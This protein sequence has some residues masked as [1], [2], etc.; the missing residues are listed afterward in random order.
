MEEA[1]AELVKNLGLLHRVCAWE[2]LLLKDIVQ[3]KGYQIVQP[4]TGPTPSSEPFLPVASLIANGEL[5]TAGI[6]SDTPESI[7]PTDGEKRKRDHR[8]RNAQAL[9]HLLHGLAGAV[10]PFFQG[11][12]A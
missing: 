6:S 8:D 2:S 10:A 5:S 12:S 4:Y 3:E 11:A 9:R 1:N 7:P